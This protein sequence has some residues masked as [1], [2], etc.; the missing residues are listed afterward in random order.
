MLAFLILSRFKKKKSNEKIILSW[1]FC[2]EAKEYKVAF[3]QDNI[4]I[5]GAVREGRQGGRGPTPEIQIN[6][7]FFLYYF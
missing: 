6:V 3:D 5:M 1:I 4:H 7:K 2:I